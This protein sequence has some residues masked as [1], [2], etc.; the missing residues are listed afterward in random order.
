MVKKIVE[1]DLF[2]E[3]YNDDKILEKKSVIEVM[4]ELQAKSEALNK[5]TS[6]PFTGGLDENII[7]DD[8]ISDAVNNLKYD[9]NADDLYINRWLKE[10]KIDLKDIIAGKLGTN[11][12]EKYISVNIND[13]QG[14]YEEKEKTKLMQAE[15]LD[16][17]LK[18]YANG[19]NKSKDEWEN[20]RLEGIEADCFNSFGDVIYNKKNVTNGSIKHINDLGNKLIKEIRENFIN[21]PESKRNFYIEE[22]IDLLETRQNNI[23]FPIDKINK[24]VSKYGIDLK[25]YPN[26]TSKKLID[27]L[28]QNYCREYTTL[29]E[30]KDAF[31]IKTDFYLYACNIESNRIIDY[32]INNKTNR[33]SDCSNNQEK[34]LTIKQIALKLAFEGETVNKEDANEIIK[35]YGYTSGHKLYQE[36]NKVCNS[37]KRIS[38]PDKSLKLLQN[39]IALF[40][41]VA[42]ILSPELQGKAYD[43][44]KILKNYL[45]EYQ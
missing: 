7:N 29:K 4:V 17:F 39:K 40:E 2:C 37:K 5:Q 34:K 6:N 38:N 15:F 19:F 32:L 11:K 45:P 44:I 28:D 41:S 1:L 10:F 23:P 18:Y 3:I 27:I 30:R 42:E 35:D 31:Q 25:D 13:Y 9:R 22:V 16:F 14:S 33:H 24:W 36:Y 12:I 26:F 43:E 20:V 21:M 8:L